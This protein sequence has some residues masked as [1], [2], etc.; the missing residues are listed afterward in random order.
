MHNN[1][2]NKSNNCYL[3]QT[4]RLSKRQAKKTATSQ[5][6]KKKLIQGVS[7]RWKTQHMK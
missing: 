4:E 2:G 7:T 1:R 5:E 3:V 6:I